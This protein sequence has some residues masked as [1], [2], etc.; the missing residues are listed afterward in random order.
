MKTAQ[1]PCK[2]ESPIFPD[3]PRDRGQESHFGLNGTILKTVSLIED[4][5]FPRE[6]GLGDNFSL[7]NLYK[8][9]K[10]DYV[11]DGQQ[12]RLWFLGQ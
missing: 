12:S 7:L 10:I 1:P 9:G 11:E 4:A 5:R 8:I 3:F 6:L 2:L